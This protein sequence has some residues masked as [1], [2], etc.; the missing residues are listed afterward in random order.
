MMLASM[1]ITGG[2]GPL[3]DPH[4]TLGAPARRLDLSHPGGV[5]LHPHFKERQN[6]TN[7]HVDGFIG[8]IHKY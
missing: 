2:R 5:R 3:H 4:Q 7:L 1:K 8:M 6:R